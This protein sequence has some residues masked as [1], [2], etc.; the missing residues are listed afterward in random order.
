MW[1]WLETLN[2]LQRHNQ[3][4]AL[5]TVTQNGGSTPR[6]VGAKMVVL[7]NGEFFG[8]IGGGNLEKLII[9]QSLRQLEVGESKTSTY[10]LGTKAGQCCGGVVEV[11][12]ESLNTGPSLYLFGAGHVGRAVCDALKGTPFQVHVID[13]RPEWIDKEGLPEGV[14]KH[15]QD[16]TEAIK[17]LSFDNKNTFAAIMT[18][19]HEVD[20]EI[21]VALMK[22]EHRFLG[23]IGSNSKWDR[24]QRRLKEKGISQDELDRVH[25]PIGLN[26][27]GKAPQEVAISL[28][29][30]LL[31]IHY[32]TGL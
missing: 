15:K 25:C 14:V 23:M 4:H 32:E 29:S 20:Q 18:H 28:A 10:P 22:T 2:K 31:S 12:I 5:V 8:S 17:S 19:S 30:Q 7:P 11:L 26:T 13:P 1:N 24:F 3:A 6:N 9:E 27:G 16:W 21:L